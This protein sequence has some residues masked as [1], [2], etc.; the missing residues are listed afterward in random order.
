MSGSAVHAG[1]THAAWVDA[2]VATDQWIEVV[3]GE[4]VARR[5]GDT[6]LAVRSPRPFTGGAER[7]APR[8]GRLT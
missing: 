7:P 6:P 8:P 5:G 2:I 1:I 3:D 4:F